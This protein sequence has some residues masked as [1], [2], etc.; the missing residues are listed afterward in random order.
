M[1]ALAAKAEVKKKLTDDEQVLRAAKRALAIKKARQRIIDF[2][3]LTSPVASDPDDVELS[4]YQDAKHHRVIAAALEEV[5]KGTPGWTRLIITMPP[6]HGKSELSS[7]RFPAW[8]MG[9]NP[10][11]QII[12]ATYGEALAEDFGRKVR[13]IMRSDAYAQVFPDV[14]LKDASQAAD[15]Q[16]TTAGGILHFVAARGAM[17][18]RGA[19]LLLIDDPLKGREEA[20]SLLIR[21][22]L[23]E[24]FTDDAMSRLMDDSARVVIIMTRWHDDDLVGRLTDPANSH[25]SEETAKQWRIL[26]LPALAVEDDP[27]GREAGEALW[28]GRFSRAY[29]EGMRQLN[30]RGFSAL[31]QGRPSPEE[32]AFFKKDHIVRYNKMADLPGELR[33]YAGSDH[34]TSEKQE[35]DKSCLVPCGVDKYGDIWILPNV[36]WQR[37]LSNVV[38]EAMLSIMRRDKPMFW[39]A[40]RDHITKSIGPFLRQRMRETQT[41]CA[42]DE[43]VPIGDKTARAQSIMGRM[44]MGRVHF[45]SFAPWFG[46]MERELLKFPNGTHDDFVDALA[47]IGLGLDK[48]APASVPRP[49]FQTLDAPKS[50]TIEWI[51]W[52]AKV[53]DHERQM[54]LLMEG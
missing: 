21:N 8:F 29:L 23:W 50:G 12:L 13:E 7:R 24:N 17:T 47:M 45:P 40:G 18:G 28:P 20:N 10:H 27:L 26:D 15:R 48:V 1:A 52:A 34:A 41:H 39:W 16:E 32:G 3:K 46:D 36:W 38:V 5:E 14:K 9:R 30:P 35:R 53:K 22:R 44:A 51:K 4:T 37:K 42:I 11:W 43:V 2:T 25:Y 54:A 33:I 19:N 6:R 49:M 31:Y